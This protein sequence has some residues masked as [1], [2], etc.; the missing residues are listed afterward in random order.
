MHMY[1]VGSING[2]D[3]SCFARLH[4]EAGGDDPERLRASDRHGRHRGHADAA[5]V[6]QGAGPEAAEEHGRRGSRVTTV[7]HVAAISK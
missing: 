7:V 1:I 2:L 5:H 3:V 6:R 4:L